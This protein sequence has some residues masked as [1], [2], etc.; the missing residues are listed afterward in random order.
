MEISQPAFS[1]PLESRLY[2]KLGVR[3]AT[4]GLNNLGSP[5]L[6]VTITSS[7]CPVISGQPYKEAD[8]ASL[9]PAWGTQWKEGMKLKL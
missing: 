9:L 2:D 1:Q 5:C 7:D 6:V 3:A 8:S 4:Y